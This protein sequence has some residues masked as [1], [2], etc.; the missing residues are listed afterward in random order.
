MKH[1]CTALVFFAALSLVTAAHPP[2]GK[3]ERLAR[4][5]MGNP[6][7]NRHSS[8]ALARSLDNYASLARRQNDADSTSVDVGT[9][10]FEDEDD[11]AIGKRTF[12][13]YGHMRFGRSSATSREK[14]YDDYGHMRFGK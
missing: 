13:D 9:T 6:P 1:L 5:V 14:K 8:L 3:L 4:L 7:N 11:V 2:R 12:D 10:D